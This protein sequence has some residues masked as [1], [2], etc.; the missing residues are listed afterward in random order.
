ATRCTRL[1]ACSATLSA[2]N[3][4][5]AITLSP[6][7]EAPKWSRETDAPSSPIQRSQPTLEA[8]ST[9]RRAR[10]GG[11]GHA[12]RELL[13][14]GATRAEEDQADRL[15]VLG[16]AHPR[17]LRGLVGGGGPDEHEPGQGTEAGQVLDRLV[18]RAV[19]ALADGVVRPDEDGGGTH[20]GGEADGGPHVVGEDQERPPE[21]PDAA[22][23][24]HAVQGGGHA[25]LPDPVVD[26]AAGGVR[27][28][29]SAALE[30]RQ[31]TS[32]E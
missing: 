21:R 26:V 10:R 30:L 1:R 6:G 4:S 27:P 28:E 25:V 24:G 8:A 14:W 3:P 13:R 18:G 12:S 32:G 15:C 2:V 5:S 16:Q 29:R 20:E 9:D 19:L 7:A 11:G 22:V 23:Q 17:G 31:V